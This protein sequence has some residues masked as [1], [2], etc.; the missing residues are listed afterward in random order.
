MPRARFNDSII[1]LPMNRKYPHLLV[2]LLD[3]NGS[4][5]GSLG[6]GNK[7]EHFTGEIEAISVK[8]DSLGHDA[9][10]QTIDLAENV[11]FDTGMDITLKMD[12]E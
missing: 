3:Q 2:E 4:G 5:Q 12:G 10:V 6:P 9:P 11:D 1:T 8:W 7:V